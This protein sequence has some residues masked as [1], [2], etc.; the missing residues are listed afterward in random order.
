MADMK[1]TDYSSGQMTTSALGSCL[2]VAIYDPVVHVAGL[3]RFMLPDSRINREKALQ[4]PFLFADTGIPLLFRRAYKLGAVKDRIVC[5]LAGASNV[6]DPTH[7][8]ELGVRNHLAA[9]QVLRKNNVKVSG[10]C[11]GGIAGMDLTMDME[12]GRIVVSQPY[13]GVVEL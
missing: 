4:N 11:V 12:T 2:A 5:K 9:C 8:L 3:L 6:L 7:F 1:A 13:G 10:E